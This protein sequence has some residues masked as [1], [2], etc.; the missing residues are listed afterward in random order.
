MKRKILIS[1]LLVIALFITVGCESKSKNQTTE[2]NTNTS[3]KNN[4]NTFKIKD[5]SFVFDQDSEFHD[6]KYKNS[7][8]LTLDESKYSL[9]LEYANKDI[10]DGRFVYRISLAY[11]DETNLE[12]FF[13]GYE[14]KKV[15][16]NGI[17][18]HKATI[19]NTTDNKETKAIVY[20]TEKNSTLYAVTTV[21]FVEANIDI[22]KLSQIFINGVTIK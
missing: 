10:Y 11:S 19:K 3:S 2:N 1:I 14:S 16:I 5:V 21:E 4:S 22:E 17:T 12:K 8:E 6:F 9:H 13:D 15:K 20:A 7:K 18:W